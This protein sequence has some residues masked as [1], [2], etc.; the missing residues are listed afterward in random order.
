MNRLLASMVAFAC[1]APA[2]A[3]D[4]ALLIGIDDYSRVDGAPA[5]T[6]A[7]AD[8]DRMAET[9]TGALGF[10]EHGVIQLTDGAATYDA[11]V[12]EVINSLIG[13]TSPGDRVVL[14][15]AG[16]GTTLPEGSPAL[17][18]HDA[19]SV[20]GKMPLSALS[21]LF[22]VIEDRDVTIILDTGFDGGPV[23]ARGVAGA[24]QTQPV[25]LRSEIALWTAASVGQFAWDD[26]D[27]G[28]FTDAWTAVIEERAAGPDGTLT[29]GELLDEVAG[30]MTGWCDLS[31][32]CL[33]SGRGLT[34]AF[35]GD[36]ATAILVVESEEPP[37]PP[38][39]PIIIDDGAPAGYVETLG[40]V[41]DLFAPS[42]DAGLT[43]AIEGGDKL[44]V[45]ETVSFTATAERPGALLLLDVAPT[46]ELAQVYPS[47]LVA[48]GATQLSPG[49][50]LT[51]PNARG[52]NGSPLRIRVTEPVGQGLLLALFI[53]SDLPQ[54]TA[55]LPAGISGGPVP[56]AGQSLFEISQGLLALE[57]DADSPIAW[58]A[59]YLPYHIEY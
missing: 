47:S 32:P 26:I 35:T 14:Y 48:K 25:D 18:A 31:G 1:A 4:R 21:E 43:L 42:N 20:L 37:A 58:S 45:G 29:N 49:Q 53:E 56:N 54:L 30:R 23:G 44:R 50:P 16:L 38:V 27:R 10:P 9:L 2:L 55:L 52:K 3:E 13:E 12:T 6:G 41:T 17:L 5:L 11:I 51:I 59:T 46:G 57:A 24:V 40:F 28:V 39:D 8:V 19:N 15:F 34:P 36:P 7:V 22:A 33:A